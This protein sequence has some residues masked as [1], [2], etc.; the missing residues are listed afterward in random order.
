MNKKI[1][2]AIC[3]TALL[4][5]SSF[6]L[7]N[8][9]HATALTVSLIDTVT[10]T[11]SGYLHEAIQYS[12]SGLDNTKS[13]A[14]YLHLEG[15]SSSSDYHVTTVYYQSSFTIPSDGFPAGLGGVYD[16]QLRDAGTNSVLTS[17]TFTLFTTV[18][19]LQSDGS[20]DGLAPFY[21]MAGM[22]VGIFCEALSKADAS[23]D[24]FLTTYD[25]NSV[26][27]SYTKWTLENGAV[28][29]VFTIPSN[30]ALGIHTIVVTDQTTGD[31]GTGQFTVLAPIIISVSPSGKAL[32]YA[33]TQRLTATASG[34][35]APLTYFWS[36]NGTVVQSGTSNYYDYYGLI[37]D[38]PAVRI[39][40]TVYDNTYIHYSATSA[41]SIITINNYPAIGID[42]TTGS[43][44]VAVG[45][46]ITFTATT[47]NGVPTSY[48]WYANSVL[49]NGVS[50][51]TFTYT[52][53]A[54][55]TGSVAVYAVATDAAAQQATS[56][57]KT[58]TVTQGVPLM[59]TLNV[60][61]NP[62][63]SGT[64]VTGSVTVSPPSAGCATPTGTVNFQV[65]VD[66]GAWT[67]FSTK[68]LDGSGQATSD[69]YPSSG[70]VSIAHT[71]KFQAVYGGDTNYLSQTSS[72]STQ[73]TVNPTP[74]VVFSCPT[75][76]TSGTAFSLT[77]T[78]QDAYS[79]AT[80][81]SY[82]GPV[83][84]A[85]ST[86]T[87]SLTQVPISN[88]IWTGQQTLTSTSSSATITASD[89]SGTLGVSTAINLDQPVVPESP[90]LL[91]IFSVVL[92]FATLAVS[93]GIRRPK[94][95][96]GKNE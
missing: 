62:A 45:Q 57:T 1:I 29:G 94:P 38:E 71:Y 85:P 8:V 84:L 49:Q 30:A 73:L 9:G 23:T 53:S 93:V 21:F 75:N 78:V 69:P 67:T 96:Q 77:V 16:V 6:A 11:N 18:T 89:S 22:Q 2:E 50:G 52:P 40:C 33:M 46:S 91:L 13:Y 51:A 17:S 64:Q 66:T 19:F 25:G 92:A 43:S 83:T 20:S 90:Q 55:G 34:G 80:L 12:G 56:S 44:P 63:N 4:V 86:G 42:I 59:G 70:G 82:S 87:L 48:A 88:G 60:N 72:S 3:I 68:T 7:L 31:T 74:H 41:D 61:P 81:T 54:V 79:G 76:V 37:A 10:G 95:V 36:K 28:W 26:S 15:S 65:Q 14:I 58:I 5:V 47:F 39:S 35:L 32:D 24:T 27:V